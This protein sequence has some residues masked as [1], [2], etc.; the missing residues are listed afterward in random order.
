[1]SMYL[2]NKDFIIEVQEHIGHFHLM[3]VGLRYAT[4]SISDPRHCEE[5][6]DTFPHEGTRTV[7]NR[8]VVWFNHTPI[9]SCVFMT[10]EEAEKFV[11]D[12]IET[13][14]RIEAGKEAADRFMRTLEMAK[15]KEDEVEREEEYDLDEVIES[16]EYDAWAN[17][18]AIFELE[19]EVDG[20]KKEIEELKEKFERL[21]T[22]TDTH[23]HNVANMVNDF[24]IRLEK[25]EQARTRPPRKPV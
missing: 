24:Y 9:D 13:W 10:I 22:G 17:A 23:V 16:I 18:H 1:M 19:D 12:K 14:N 4:F 11:R 21:K 3:G 20:L 7:L 25:L 2:L 6:G 5:L 15:D 8:N